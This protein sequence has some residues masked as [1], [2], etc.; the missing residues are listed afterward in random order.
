MPS[1]K[2][3]IIALSP[4]DEFDHRLQRILPANRTHILWRNN[5]DQIKQEM[6]SE[7]YDIFILQSTACQDRMN[8]CMDVLK[9]IISRSPSTQILFLVEPQ[10]VE[11]GIQALSL[12]VYQY[13][14]MPIS[15]TELKLLIEAALER[16]PI[17][18]ST[19][20]EDLDSKRDRL[21]NLV[22]ASEKMQRV[23]RQI[24]QA[25]GSEVNI[26][27]LGET[28]TGKDLAAQTIHQLSNRSDAPFLPINLGA[29]PSDLVASE[30]F[31]HEKGTFTGAI[32]Q[33]KGIFEKAEHGI[34]FLDEIEAIDEKVQISLLRLIEQKKFLRLGGK[35]AI[36]NSARLIAS[37]NEDLQA[38]IERGVFRK[39]LYYRLDVFHITMPTL[40]EN[41]EDIPL[42]T[43]EF[44][45]RYNRSYQKKI[46]VISAECI[47][48]F[49][50]YDWPGNA[51][52]LK[53]VIQRA[54]IVCES[55]EI[56]LEH[57]PPRFRTIKSSMP[58]N[59]TVTF[60]IGTPLEQVEKEMI[61]QALSAAN[62]NRTQAAE[63]L[64]ISRRA[65]YNKL[66]K[67]N[68]Q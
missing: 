53:N 45:A 8:Y 14:K 61:L 37:S 40:R 10:D 2:I 44:L 33:S 67:H 64:G 21:G 29:I 47:Q 27:L 50:Q 11:V 6:Q 25:A 41:L 51:R 48:A 60:E 16:N 68:I 28:G 58:A 46:T 30:L 36:K 15:D 38:L 17:V 23:Y 22:G 59:P 35:Q 12:G 32:K 5:I 24:Y 65:I 3:K 55:D 54:A 66:R 49:Q 31:G 1:M 57:L 43:K 63:L 62:N 52:E 13:A 20:P 9:E 26:L 34:V 39:D 19:L 42:L 7:T 4:D 18:S 56:K